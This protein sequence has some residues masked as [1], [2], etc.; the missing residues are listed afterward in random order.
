MDF[1]STEKTPFIT[2]SIKHYAAIGILLLMSCL[3][4][5]FVPT[6]SSDSSSQ[7]IALSFLVVLGIIGM[8]AVIL[9]LPVITVVR[10]AFIASFFFKGELNFYKID[11]IEDPSGFNISLTLLTGLILL[12]YDLFIGN[13]TCRVKVFPPTFSI[14]IVALFICATMSVIYG[15][16]NLLGWFSLWSFST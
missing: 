4:G 8:L 2:D 7:M 12:G 3:L 10:F 6:I 14:L 1:Q 11:E 5:L 13:K 15:G 16:S 9:E